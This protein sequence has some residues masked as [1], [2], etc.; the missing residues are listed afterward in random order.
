MEAVKMRN[1]FGIGAAIGAAV[2]WVIGTLARVI[3]NGVKAI[4]AI[5]NENKKGKK[6]G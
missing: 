2:G 5:C 4:F 3:A 6:D 1:A